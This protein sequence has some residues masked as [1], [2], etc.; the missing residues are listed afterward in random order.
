MVL[1]E[2]CLGCGASVKQEI[3]KLVWIKNSESLWKSLGG[4]VRNRASP[5]GDHL[6]NEERGG[7]RG[8]S[9]RRLRRFFFRYTKPGKIVKIHQIHNRNR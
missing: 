7:V 5:E 9:P 4:V 1:G 8:V 3:T 2:S 6:L